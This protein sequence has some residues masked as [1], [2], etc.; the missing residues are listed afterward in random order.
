MTPSLQT[1]LADFD[2]ELPLAQARTI[3]AGWYRDPE[4]YVRECRTAFADC[5]LA[6]GRRDLVAEPGTYLTAD[7]ADE[8]ILIV[9]DLVGELRAFTNVCRHRAALVMLGE[10]GRA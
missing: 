7:I 5:W 9:R 6:V 10:C 8:P 3:P 2:D 4:L 1:L